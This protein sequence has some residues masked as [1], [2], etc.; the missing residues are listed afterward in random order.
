MN[1]I[2]NKISIFF[3]KTNT[4][5]LALTIGFY[6]SLFIS[7]SNKTLLLLACL[8][9]I[10]LYFVS[11]NINLA[12]FLAFVVLLPFAK[13]KALRILI[14]PIENINRVAFFDIEYFFPIYIADFFLALLAYL[15][16]RQKI[17]KSSVK[18]FIKSYRKFIPISASFVIFLFIAILKIPSSPFPEV[19]FLSSIQLIRLFIVFS[20][21]AVLVNWKKYSSALTDVISASLIFQSTWAILQ[22]INNGPLG[23]DVEVFLPDARAVRT[24]AE[25]TEIS[26][27]SGVFFEPSIF[28]TF[29]LIHISMLSYVLLKNKLT[30]IQRKIYS[31][32]V[33]LGL[34]AVIFTGSRAI[35]GLFAIVGIW[36][37]KQEGHQLKSTFIKLF[38]SK[39][40]LFYSTLGFLIVSAF[41]LPTL[42]GRLKTSPTLLASDGSAMY[43]IELALYS[44]RLAGKQLLG[45]GLNLSPY[46]FATLLNSEKYVF[47]PAH[48]HNIFF[49]ILAETG[50]PGLIFFFIFIYLI[51]R[52]LLQK[53][54]ALD[55]FSLGALVFL[56]CAQVYPIFL[57]H[58]EI[59]T[60]F[61][62]YSGIYFQRILRN[63][64][65]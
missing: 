65:K 57:N 61:F 26:R 56:L 60:Y 33:L 31:V 32:A 12:I 17:V 20:L 11:K 25:N 24:A 64:K 5:Y 46:H 49:Q 21:A 13:G 39:R 34:I 22:K 42:A 14:L 38:K 9:A 53:R 47:D 16:L 4:A 27:Q 6:A 10:A 29:L 62:V 19:I 44:T 43:R 30:K 35:Y 50:V 45:S 63:D 54:I 59:L 40:L 15:Y 55:H 41:T 52:P 3:K 36:L 2:I 28:G 23:K 37:I 1:F 51:F 8:Y 18:K 7:N 58:P 48:P